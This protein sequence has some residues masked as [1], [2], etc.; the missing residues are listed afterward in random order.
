MVSNG[1][2][3]GPQMEKMNITKNPPKNKLEV[4]VLGRE[5]Q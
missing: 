1:G 5:K 2:H 3:A 4:Y